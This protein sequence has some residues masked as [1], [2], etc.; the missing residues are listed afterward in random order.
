MVARTLRIPQGKLHIPGLGLLLVGV[1]VLQGQL[2][3]HIHTY[4]T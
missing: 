2:G 1:D 3:Q 4:L